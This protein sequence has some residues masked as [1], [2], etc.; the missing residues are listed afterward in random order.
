MIIDELVCCYGSANMD[1]RSFHLNYEINAILYDLK[2]VEKLCEIY[3]ED[4]T[5][6]RL[7]EIEENQKLQIKEQL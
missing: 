4:I 5:K 2:T 3:R 7:L 1:V 6:C